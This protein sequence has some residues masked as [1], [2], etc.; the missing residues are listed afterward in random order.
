MTSK[1]ISTAVAFAALALLAFVPSAPAFKVLSEAGSAAGQTL[2]TGGLS[3]DWETGR[4]YVADPH[5]NRVDVFG[6]NGTFEEAFGWGVKNGVAEFQV[7]TVSCRKGLPGSGAGQLSQPTSVA[8]DNDPLSPSFHNV[9]VSDYGNGRIQ[10]FTAAGEFVLAFG[11]GVDK[12]DGGN[13]CTAASGHLCGGGTI[14]TG[15]GQFSVTLSQPPVATGPGGA[16]Y[17]ADSRLKG[18]NESEGFESRVQR[19][20]SSGA[21]VAQH[22]LGEG[23]VAAAQGL[24]VDSTGSF[25]FAAQG[26]VGLRKFDS[27]GTEVKKIL[28]QVQINA[29]VVDS[30]DHLF[31]AEDSGPGSRFVEYDASGSP[32]RR[33]GYGIMERNP[34]GL[35]P[36]SSASGDLYVVEDSSYFGPPENR[37]PE[38]ARVLHLDFPDPGPLIFPKPC[39]ASPLGNTKATLSAEINPEGNATTYHFEYV[40]DAIFQQDITNLGAGHGFDHATRAPAAAVDDPS[41]P[42]DVVLHKASQEAGVVPDTKYHC[43]VVAENVAGSATGQEG[44]FTSLPPLQIGDTWSSDVGAE[45]ATLNVTVN[46]LGIPTS[47]YFEYV[48]EATYRADVEKAEGE[49]NDKEEAEEHGFD[50]ALKAP[51]VGAGE[52]PIE[53]G[54]GESFK[55]GTATLTGLTPGTTYYFRVIA[56]DTYFPTGLAG[57]PRTLRTYS[58]EEGQLP[59]GRAYEMVSPDQKGGAE[60]AVPGRAGGLFAQEKI[61]RTQAAAG[62]GEALTYTSWTSFGSPEGAPS[63]SQYLSKRTGTGWGT[64]NVSPFGFMLNVLE[65]PYR[66]FSPDLGFAAFVISQPP[67]T[68]EA[69]EGVENLYL[70]DN[71]TG[72]L[73]ALTIEAPQFTPINEQGL[74]KFCTSYAGASA[75]GKRAF[76]AANGAMADAPPGIGFSLYEWSAGEGLKLVSVLPGETPAPP[77][78][79]TRFGAEAGFCS[80]DQGIVAHSVSE[81]GSTV[82]WTYGGNF[83]GGERPLLARIGGAET[84]QLDAKSGGKG[85]SGKGTFWAATPDGSRAFFTAPGRLTASA[86]AADQL[87]RYD[88]EE[89]TLV[90]LT[91]GAIVPKIAGVI[92]ASEDGSYVYFVAENPLTDSEE[93]ATGQK[94]EEDANNLYVWHEGEGLRFIGALSLLDAGVWDSSPNR[95]T[96]RVTPDGRHLAFLSVEAE[97]LASYNNTIFPG[98]ACQPGNENKLIDDPRCAEAFLYA[99]ESNEL[100]CASCNPAGTRPVGPVELPFWSNPFEGP[101]YLSDD[102]SKLFFETRDVLSGADENGKRDVYEFERAGSGTCTSESPTFSATSDGC[103]FLISSGKSED[104]TYFLDASSSGRDVF[105]TTRSALVGWDTNANYDVYDARIAGGFP[106]PPAEVPPCLAEACKPTP[107]P[108]PAGSSSPAT[109]T[110]DGPGNA[111]KVRSRCAKGKVRR[112]GRCQKPHK[113]RK[114]KGRAGNGRHGGRAAR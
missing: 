21:F 111:G 97:A 92:G 93:N 26:G 61:V 11:G 27:S 89:R 94:A 57:P 69:Q 9:Y 78:P 84:I 104:E 10:K 7:C 4:L 36:Y 88:T 44:T 79:K 85:P 2:G 42:A 76:F 31:A 70:R 24:A 101:R 23:R 47:G 17:V 64:E 96:A 108:P 28:P 72:A 81:D 13:V 77:A 56:T 103:L 51:D 58:S 54:A 41:L 22:P 91:P 105:F 19:F 75:D 30:A 63:A 37:P 8:V 71:T 50:R 65:P 100:I 106:E 49:G 107:T 114:Q 99:A 80:M 74:N 102:G 82:F 43:R 113:Q 109:A 1:R 86:G 5:N 112:K 59:D 52:D 6:K 66:G 73:Q 33:F 110:F 15:P 29:I 38:H 87:Y 83:S 18:T 12:T 67:L 55:A 40:T 53:F 14:G 32:L 3:V 48:D 90:D 46:P 95:L 60:V 39:N 62:S 45:T 20:E 98:G 68:E 35:A 34:S 25:W 16:V